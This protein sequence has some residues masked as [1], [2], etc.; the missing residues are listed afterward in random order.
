MNGSQATETSP[1]VT[2][3]PS[4]GEMADND[5]SMGF[6]HQQLQRVVR[7]RACA[8]TILHVTS[9]MFYAEHYRDQSVFVHIGLGGK[10]A[11]NP[12]AVGCP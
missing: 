9:A 5:F 12:C 3:I 2:Y 7:K 6:T 1:G 4:P 11:Q 8:Y 10:V